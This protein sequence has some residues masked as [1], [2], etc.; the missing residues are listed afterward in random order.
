[1]SGEGA[2]ASV[3]GKFVTRDPDYAVP[4]IAIALERRFNSEHLSAIINKLLHREN[5]DV[6]EFEFFIQD[7][8]LLGSVEEHL[9][10]HGLIVENEIEIEYS[11]K[12]PIPEVLDSLTHDDW[13][14]AV[15]CAR[16]GSRDLILTG[17]YDCSVTIWT[18]AGKKLTTLAGHESP[19]KSVRWVEYDGKNA[20]FISTSHDE[21]AVLWSWNVERNSINAMVTCKG[22]ER[23]V[24][25][26]DVDV[27]SNRFATS[28]F[29]NVVKLWSTSTEETQL[30]V[31]KEEAT[32]GDVKRSRFEVD[33]PTVRRFTR[34]PLVSLASHT[35]AVTAVKFMNSSEMLTCSMDCTLKVWD[36]EIGG[37][38]NNLLGS[39]AFLD[40]CYS[41]LNQSIVTAHADRHIRLWDPRSKQGSVVKANF[42]SH[43]GWVTAV[44]WSPAQATQFISSSY[45]TLVKLWDTRSTKTPLYDMQGHEDRILCCDWSIPEYMVSGGADNQLKLFKH[46][47]PCSKAGSQLQVHKEQLKS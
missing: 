1:M 10:E 42:T 22:H 38:S 6:V 8:I 11:V 33:H 2:E 17:S 41:P 5:D 9:E 28:G 32:E 43:S 13:V 24:D 44:C 23:S 45:D 34:T 19:V 20:R 36:I 15:H 21:T 12:C 30:D 40:L 31:K 29:D 46:E 3:Q 16:I 39:K 25:C 47:A 4:L 35:E 14:S 7:N 26:V 18:T 37:F 27:P